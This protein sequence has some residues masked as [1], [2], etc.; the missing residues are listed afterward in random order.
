[1]YNIAV[2]VQRTVLETYECEISAGSLEEAMDV[3]Y[4]HFST[5]P[6]SELALHT[7]RRTDEDTLSTEIIN[8]QNSDNVYPL[9]QSND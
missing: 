8:I 4:E 9:G 7:R 1:M 6:N 2:D 5:F 3:A